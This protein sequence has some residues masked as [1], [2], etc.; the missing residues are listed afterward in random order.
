MKVVLKR[1]IYEVNYIKISKKVYDLRDV[2][3]LRL[4]LGLNYDF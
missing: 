1:F 4:V 3:Q 2:L